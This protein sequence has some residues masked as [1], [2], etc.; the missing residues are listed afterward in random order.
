MSRYGLFGRMAP[1]R[2][3][4]AS[5][6]LYDGI[7]DPEPTNSF[8]AGLAP[9][10]STSNGFLSG[11]AGPPSSGGFLSGLAPERPPSNDFLAGLVPP[12]PRRNALA[13]LMLNPPPPQ[14]VE[15]N[16][17]LAALLR[18]IEPKPEPRAIGNVVLDDGEISYTFAIYDI[19]NP[20]EVRNADYVFGAGGK[21]FWYIGKTKNTGTRF[22]DHH[23]LDE[24]KA[25]GATEI[26]V[27]V[28]G[29]NAYVDYHDAEVR[30]IRRWKPPLNDILYDA[31]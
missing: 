26:W 17:L 1:G 21:F 29:P 18:R 16:P 11:L 27:H 19:D 14:P 7:L 5:P 23:K 8:L 31:A 4:L 28:P 9:P 15:E 20:P 25:A 13:D 22:F 24:A 10:R 6:S 3:Y 12:T 30:L 2:N